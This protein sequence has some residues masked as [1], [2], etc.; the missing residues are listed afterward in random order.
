[1]T[2]QSRPIE[3]ILMDRLAVTQDIARANTEQLRL[4]Q[5]ASGFMVLD[6]KD[7]RD[8]TEREG[9]G[10]ARSR[11]EAALE[12]NAERINR[13]DARLA[14]LDVELAAAM[15]ETGE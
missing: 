10:E 6:M 9:R 14:A 12:E 7:A 8:G 5:K 13:L 1:M 3:D 11:N 15:K 4:N 2:G